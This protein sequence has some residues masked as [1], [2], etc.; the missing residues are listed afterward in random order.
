MV[1]NGQGQEKPFEILSSEYAPGEF[2]DRIW[3]EGVLNQI[4]K[5]AGTLP[6]EQGVQNITLQAVEPGLVLE[7]I[8][9]YQ[10]KNK[11][12]ASYLGPLE[13]FQSE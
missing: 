5:T 7:K 3:S 2:R 11:P 1:S 9:I 10:T 6:F 4:H 13:S 12:K 8:L